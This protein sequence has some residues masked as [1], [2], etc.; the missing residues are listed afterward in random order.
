MIDRQ[1]LIWDMKTVRFLADLGIIFND[2]VVRD[3]E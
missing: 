3:H 1:E 2:E